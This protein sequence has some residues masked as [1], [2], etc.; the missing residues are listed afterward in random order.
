MCASRALYFK[1]I[2][3]PVQ[4]QIFERE[5][6]VFATTTSHPRFP[7][8]YRTIFEILSRKIKNTD[9]KKNLLQNLKKYINITINI[10]HLSRANK[11]IIR[12]FCSKS[13]SRR[14]SFP[15]DGEKCKPYVFIPCT[16][17]LN[18]THVKAIY[19]PSLRC[20]WRAARRYLVMAITHFHFSRG[21]HAERE[22]GRLGSI[23]A[24]GLGSSLRL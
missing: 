17:F 12:E 15:D 6:N 24:A 8:T 13:K 21:T 19:A 16:S 9:L 3:S 18:A 22:R 5:N 1:S 23:E 4:Q 11:K 20:S 10:S 7:K 14:N 2:F